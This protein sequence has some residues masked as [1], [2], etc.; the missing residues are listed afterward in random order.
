LRIAAWVRR[1]ITNI[2]FLPVAGLQRIDQIDETVG[3]VRRREGAGNAS[4]DDA[5][6]ASAP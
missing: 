1:F 5:D 4:G 2:A 3:R 6:I